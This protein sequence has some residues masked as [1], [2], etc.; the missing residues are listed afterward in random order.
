M[1]DHSHFFNEAGE[2]MQDGAS[3]RFEMQLDAESAYEQAYDD[4]NEGY[5][6]NYDPSEYEDDTE[7]AD[8]DRDYL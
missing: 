6:A 7:P 8:D 5:W 3:M 4:Y 1:S 2:P